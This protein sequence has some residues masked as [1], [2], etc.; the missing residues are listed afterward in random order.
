MRKI[1]FFYIAFAMCGLL[2]FILLRPSHHD[3]LSFFGFAENNETEINY[4]YPVI[5]DRILVTPGQSVEKGDELLHL[6]RRKSPE[7]LADQ[8][9]RI[10]EL[11]AEELLWKQK[12]QD[13]IDEAILSRKA[14]VS[15]LM[16]KVETAEKELQFKRSLAEGLETV[17]ASKAS[18]KPL[19]D[20]LEA[21]RSELSAT[22]V[23]FDQRLKALKGELALGPIP[24]KKQIARL[25]AEKQF[26]SDQQEIHIVVRAPGAGLIGNIS[27]KEAEHIPSYTALLSFYEPHSGIIQG[28]V[29]EDL[30]LEVKLG[31][32][33]TVSSLKDDEIAYK[34]TVIGLGSRIVA[35]PER[36]RKVPELKSYGREVLVQID[37]N[38]DFLQKEKVSL[39]YTSSSS[40]N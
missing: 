4:N 10:E 37:Q 27:C 17:N 26:E 28:Y 14:A 18:Y 34:G 16:L 20:E 5:V 30:T 13:Q 2:L 36:L 39:R 8:T 40:Q 38:N 12:K 1:N 29:H 9:Y 21:L 19:E 3:E 32:S 35:I 7:I 24:L 15:A 6:V 33:F 11:K 31:D 23:R 25:E 22:K